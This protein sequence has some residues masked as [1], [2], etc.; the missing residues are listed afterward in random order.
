MKNTNKWGT[1]T[2]EHLEE[3]EDEF[4]IIADASLRHDIDDKQKYLKFM[5]CNFLWL[6]FFFTCCFCL[7]FFEQWVE[8]Q[9]LV[10]LWC[11]IPNSPYLRNPWSESIL[12]SEKFSS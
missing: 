7:H 2:G 9:V 8:N 3:S 6:F 12:K 1:V 5:N 4:V 10:F 11:M